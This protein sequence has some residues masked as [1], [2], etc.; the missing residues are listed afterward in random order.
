MDSLD[1]SDV[2]TG[3]VSLFERMLALSLGSRSDLTNAR[4]SGLASHA[5]GTSETYTKYHKDMDPIL[6]RSGKPPRNPIVGLTFVL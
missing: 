1:L 6:V 2:F 5:L 3:G 4:K